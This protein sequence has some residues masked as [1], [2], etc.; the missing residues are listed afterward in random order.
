MA[1][2]ID[3]NSVMKLIEENFNNKQFSF[4]KLVN[5]AGEYFK[6][7]VPSRII[8]VILA[9]LIK[10]KKI[11][12]IESM[13]KYKAINI[14]SSLQVIT[15]NLNKIGYEDLSKELVF[16]SSIPVVMIQFIKDNINCLAEWTLEDLFGKIAQI[17]F[18]ED[19][20]IYIIY[21]RNDFK[22]SNTDFKVNL[23]DLKSYEDLVSKYDDYKNKMGLDTKTVLEKKR[24]TDCF[25]ND[26]KHIK[27]GE[28][29]VRTYGLKSFIDFIYYVITKDWQND[30]GKALQIIKDND[31]TYDSTF[32]NLKIKGLP[33]NIVMTRF[34]NNKLTVKGLSSK[35]LEEIERI[36]TLCGV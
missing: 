11:E 36:K 14:E 31:L 30:L 8:F 5:S 34:K 24:Y 12:E 3:S 18:E 35:H 20:G 25:K 10:Q 33:G 21:D 27:K 7:F 16:A 1:K 28:F 19:T 29:I 6:E 32:R 13:K 9:D 22:I 23:N 26:F 2:K 15:N 17:K 4:S